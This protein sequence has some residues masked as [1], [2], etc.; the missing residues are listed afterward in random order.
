VHHANP[1]L[2]RQKRVLHFATS[3]PNPGAV[4]VLL[5]YGAN[6]NT[7]D[8]IENFTPL[9][10]SAAE[11]NIEVVKILLKYGADTSITDDDG[12]TAEAFALQNNHQ[13]VAKLLQNN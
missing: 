4:E 5:E 9:M 12:D 10:N 2:K 13:E 6:I 7:A 8:G 11:G 1:A 3:G